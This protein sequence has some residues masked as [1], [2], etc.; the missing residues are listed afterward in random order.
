[1]VNALAKERRVTF[2]GVTYISTLS[3]SLPVGEM[4]RRMA[5]SMP[6]AIGR[7]AAAFL[8]TEKLLPQLHQGIG[9]EREP[10]GRQLLRISVLADL[11]STDVARLSSKASARFRGSRFLSHALARKL[12]E[13]AVRFRL[14]TDDL[15]QVRSVAA[16][17]YVS[18]EGVAGG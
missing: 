15:S 14:P 12:Y 17:I 7:M 10:L 3:P 5:L 6:A 13:I 16:D 1:I 4:A 8:G 11:G 18:L 9:E 2:N